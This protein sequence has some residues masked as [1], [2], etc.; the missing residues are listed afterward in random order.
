MVGDGTAFVYVCSHGL[1]AI[2]VT[3]AP[4][5]EIATNF[6]PQTYSSSFFLNSLTDD[7]KNSSEA[8]KQ[9]NAPL[10]DCLITVGLSIRVETI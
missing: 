3:C 9:D 7:E 8:A 2:L 6:P 5:A 4:M 1:T 10:L